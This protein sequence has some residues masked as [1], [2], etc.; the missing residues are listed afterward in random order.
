MKPFV[1][2][3]CALLLAQPAA[4]G[5]LL[6]LDNPALLAP[7]NG[8]YAYG[9]VFAASS[10]A[11]LKDAASEQWSNYSSLNGNNLDL[12]SAR[13]GVGAV[14]NGYALGVLQRQ[15]WLGQAS[16]DTLDVY[17]AQQL[18]L[19]LQPGAVYP[20]EYSVRGFEARGVSAGTSFALE[21][22]AHSL[23]WGV[24]ASLLQGTRVKSQSAT[25]RATVLTPSTPS[26]EGNTVNDDSQLDTV[27][28]GFNANFQAG[29]PQGRGYSVDL[30]LSYANADGIQFE[31]TVADAF[32]EM[33]WTGVPE[34]TLSGTS[35]FNG[36]FP[37]GR[38][39]R[40]DFKESLPVKQALRFSIPV[41]PVQ[42]EVADSL[43]GA[44]NFP[45]L[46][47]RTLQSAGMEVGV[48]YDFFFKT[49]GLRWSGKQGSVIVRC[50]SLNPDQARALMLGFEI[51][52]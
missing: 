27:A 40:V 13:M 17:R 36:Q 44:F 14:W 22:P 5:D 9:H 3:V 49:V 19:S 28:N 32:S 7:G 31:W 37:S 8:A 46:G 21:G 11:P 26:V 48:D 15:E 42:L 50:D 1:C 18:G 45:S 12:V 34:V 6:G 23:R 25:G 16:R 41:G 39:V 51:R 20:L 2:L 52:L 4:A 33:A 10:Y 24:S 47:L 30:G 38:K 43:M 35:V 29:A